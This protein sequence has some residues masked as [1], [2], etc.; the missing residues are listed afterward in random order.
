MTAPPK[1]RAALSADGKSVT[2][3]AG[4]WRH[5]FPVEHLDTIWLPFYRRLRDRVGGRYRAFY[6][7]DVAALEA[8]KARIE[9]RARAAG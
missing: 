8:V 1:S 7:D 6:E 4:M 9:A 3:K 2:F 5:T